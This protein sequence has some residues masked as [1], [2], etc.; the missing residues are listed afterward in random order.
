MSD[1]VGDYCPTLRA[2]SIAKSQQGSTIGGLIRFRASDVLGIC[3]SGRVRL[4]CD[5]ANP[6]GLTLISDGAPRTSIGILGS[7]TPLRVRILPFNVVS[8]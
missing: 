3:V 6:L 2:F 8:R 1:L 5:T 4:S 7:V